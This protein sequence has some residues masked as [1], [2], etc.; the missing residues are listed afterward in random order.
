MRSSRLRTG[1]EG[2]SKA[3]SVVLEEAI[4]QPNSKATHLAAVDGLLGRGLHQ[5]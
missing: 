1:R 5:R 3:Q 4:N 2:V